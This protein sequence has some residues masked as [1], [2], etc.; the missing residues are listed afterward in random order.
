MWYIDQIKNVNTE[1]LNIK[2]RHIT[3]SNK[4]CD[5][6]NKAVG[7]TVILQQ[8]FWTNKHKGNGGYNDNKN[9]NCTNE[10]KIHC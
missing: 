8:L 4:H 1:L 10:E 7:K 5:Q 9:W 6:Q 2:Y 3:H